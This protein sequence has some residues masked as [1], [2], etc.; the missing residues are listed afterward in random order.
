VLKA[1]ANAE[2]YATI[3]SDL[4][5]LLRAEVHIYEKEFD[6]AKK[7]LS[8]VKSCIDEL[9]TEALPQL[10]T[11]LGFSLIGAEQ[12]GQAVKSLSVL[13]R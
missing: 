5:A 8:A 2:S 10:W 11:R 1:Y 6:H 12:S 3:N 9:V 4:R 13:A 7:I